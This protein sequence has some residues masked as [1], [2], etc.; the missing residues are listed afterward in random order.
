MEGVDDLLEAIRS[1]NSEFHVVLRDPQRLELV[2]TRVVLAGVEGSYVISFAAPRGA[3][4]AEW[5]SS[6]SR[7]NDRPELASP[8][9]GLIAEALV[10]PVPGGYAVSFS[11][12]SDP[13]VRWGFTADAI[14]IRPWTQG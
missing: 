7:W 6:C 11:D 4:A 9:A 2:L 12:R 5:D 14:S 3:R 10:K 13:L 1:L 8:V